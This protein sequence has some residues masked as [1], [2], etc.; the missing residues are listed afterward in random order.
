MRKK[1][2]NGKR[3]S[4]QHYRNSSAILSDKAMSNESSMKKEKTYLDYTAPY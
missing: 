2:S 1:N 3:I 4:Q